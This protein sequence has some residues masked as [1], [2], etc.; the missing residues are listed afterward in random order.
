MLISIVPFLIFYSLLITVLQKNLGTFTIPVMVYG[1]AICIFGMA[2]LLLYLQNKNSS[3]RMLLV[4]AILF[5]I[6]DSMIALQKF[7]GVQSWYPVAI[8][9]TYI[10]AQFLI[11]RFMIASE[12]T[13]D[14]I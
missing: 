1:M 4:G 8:M 10:M 9:A 5:I 3:T 13:G 7:L 2:A 11:F 6:S 12:K 14:I